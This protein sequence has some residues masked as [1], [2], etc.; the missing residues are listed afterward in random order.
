MGKEELQVEISSIQQEL[1]NLVQR[2]MEKR[3]EMKDLKHDKAETQ[4]A[5]KAVEKEFTA[6]DSAFQEKLDQLNKLRT[7]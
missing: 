3:K 7:G 1:N 2:R 6:I 4:V 5:I